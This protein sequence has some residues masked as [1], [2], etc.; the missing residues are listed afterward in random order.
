MAIS[1]GIG[2]STDKDHLQAAKEAIRQA[3]ARLAKDKI[4]LALVFSSVEFAHPAV[5]KAIHSALGEIPV[6]GSTSLAVIT[7][8]GIFKHGLAVVLFNLPKGVTFS[9]ALVKEIRAKTLPASGE[10]LAVKLLRDIKDTYRDFALIFCDGLIRD[11]SGLITGLQERLG[12]S[13]PLVGGLASDDL[14]FKRTYLY[15]NQGIFTDAAAGVLWA[16]RLHFGSGVKHGWRPLGK[17]RHITRSRENIVQEIDGQPAVKVYE[18]YF[19]ETIE[20]LRKDLKRISVFY[21]LGIYLAGEKEYLLR[22]ILSIEDDGSLAFQGD[23]AQGSLV[24][25][26]IGTKESCLEATYQAV[27]DVKRSLGNKKISLALVFDSASR[28]ILL[29]RQAGRELDIIR[30]GLGEDTPVIG[31]YTYGEEAPL[32]ELYYL[33]KTYFHNQTITILGI[34]DQ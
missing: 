23:V 32:R 12:K 19:A 20:Q 2:L 7:N 34:A 24:R 4:D 14:S 30:Q 29:G 16:G 25:L 1:V 15:F 10:E 13:F 21:P 5:I 27:Q 11:A 18:E 28:Y 9:A 8:E 31:I 33:G 3:R 26:M 17:P 6:L 22:N